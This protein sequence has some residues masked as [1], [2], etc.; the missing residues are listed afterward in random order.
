MSED[1]RSDDPHLSAGVLTVRLCAVRAATVEH[2]ALVSLR[3]V[4]P[5]AHAEVCRLAAPKL[6][7]SLFRRLLKRCTEFD[8]VLRGSEREANPIV[9]HSVGDSSGN[10]N[11]VK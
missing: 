8:G 7:G 1:H 3:E 5:S 2:Y 11:P 9:G 10:L 4:V 6:A